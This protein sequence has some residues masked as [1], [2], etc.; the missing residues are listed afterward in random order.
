MNTEIKYLMDK[1]AETSVQLQRL[2]ENIIKIAAILETYGP[3]SFEYV[4]REQAA[5]HLGMSKASIDKYTRDGILEKGPAGKILW[6]SLLKL[7]EG[8]Q[9]KES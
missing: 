8:K 6:K 1:M 5:K 4:T 2:E 3:K 7:K 9:S